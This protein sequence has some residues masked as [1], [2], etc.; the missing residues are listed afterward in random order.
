MDL[1]LLVVTLEPGR[2]VHT[3]I[4]RGGALEFV[5]GTANGPFPTPFRSVVFLEIG[6]TGKKADRYRRSRS[7][8]LTAL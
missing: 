5:S 1:L 7:S 3:P 8:E 2:I 6:R 4:E